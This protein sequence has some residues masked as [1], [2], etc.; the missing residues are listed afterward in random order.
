MTRKRARPIR[1]ESPGCSAP[2]QRRGERRGVCS[3]PDQREPEHARDLPVATRRAA[4]QRSTSPTS[5]GAPARHEPDRARPPRAA[6]LH[7][8]ATRGT[9]SLPHASRGGGAVQ[10]NS[11]RTSPRV[12]QPLFG[13]TFSTTSASASDPVPDAIRVVEEGNLNFRVGP[14]SGGPLGG[15]KPPTPVTRAWPATDYTNSF[16]RRDQRRALRHRLWLRPP[17]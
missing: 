11:S 5:T 16:Q 13:E 15:T 4:R 7:A 12:R 17:C 8:Q 1:A 9:L 14:N 2:T 6:A 3:R 10:R